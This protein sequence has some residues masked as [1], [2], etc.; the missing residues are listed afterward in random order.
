MIPTLR[1]HGCRERHM[2]RRLDGKTKRDV[3]TLSC[4]LYLLLVSTCSVC[5][6]CLSHT[7]LDLLQVLHSCTFLQVYFHLF[8]PDHVHHHDPTSLPYLSSQL[9][10][11]LPSSNQSTYVRLQHARH[12]LL[13]CH[14]IL[15]SMALLLKRSFSMSSLHP[16]DF[17]C[18]TRLLSF[19]L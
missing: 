11:S 14:R 16:I 7:Q 18:N 1:R 4:A 13:S 19:S 2:G 9:H 8:S 10:C 5:L 17:G 6:H 3:S 12:C 15:P